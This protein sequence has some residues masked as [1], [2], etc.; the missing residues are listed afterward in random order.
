MYFIGTSQIF[1]LFVSLIHPHLTIVDHEKSKRAI[2]IQDRFET[3]SHG[4]KVPKKMTA[5]W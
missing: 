1:F 4:K 3:T 5:G 2:L